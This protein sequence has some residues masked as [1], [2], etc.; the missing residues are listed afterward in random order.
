MAWR[1][2]TNMREWLGILF[3][4]KKKFFFPA[5]VMA[6]GVAIGSF[7]MERKYTAEARFQRFNDPAMQQVG[8][9]GSVGSQLS[10]I[11]QFMREDLQGRNAIEQVV[12]DL[13]ASD[14]Y[15]RGLPQWQFARTPDGELTAKGASARYQLVSALRGSIRVYQQIQSDQIDL[16]G[17]SFTSP[18]GRLASKVA[19]Q[20]VANYVR[21]TRAQ[22]D[23]MLQNARGFF[24]NEVNRYRARVQ[25]LETKRLR[26]EID[27]PGLSPDDPASLDQRL[28]T[29]RAQFE[30]VANALS[31][32]AQ[33]RRRL[34]EWVAAQPEYIAR[35]TEID[36]PEVV[37]LR[38]RRNVLASEI[39]R[40]KFEMGMTDDHPRITKMHKL[41]AELERQI[42]EKQPRISGEQVLEPNTPR[43][44]AMKEVE[45]LAGELAALE[46]QR[47]EYNSQ[48]EQ[49]E[50]M[51]RNF[52]VVRNDH[53]RLIRDLEEARGQLVFWEDNLRRTSVALSLEIAQRGVRLSIVQ[54]APDVIRPSSPTLLGIIGAALTAGL[55]VGAGL[56]VLAEVLDHS[57]HSV[58]Q[59]VDGLKLPVLGAVNQIVTPGVAVRRRLMAVAVYPALAGVLV[60]ALLAVFYSVH[61]SL[62]ASGI[63]GPGNLLRFLLAF[64]R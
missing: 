58:E 4:H 53:A 44:E 46:R 54:R 36:N 40:M 21:R 56:I 61:V 35:S 20:I 30:A 38:S 10:P 25:E 3:R 23:Q 47:D 41:I 31:I 22:L 1:K 42:S 16:I 57:Y 5:L 6:I 52:F 2:P 12:D 14:A 37:D 49:M 60:V 28:V 17:V 8:G 32:T 50:L 45:L 59:A 11:R 19:N 27:N 64:V 51:K 18:D 15:V 29:V 24:E 7:L 63:G 26:F 48:L 13:I 62:E 39:D 9:A 43:M 33:K 55:A 34:Q